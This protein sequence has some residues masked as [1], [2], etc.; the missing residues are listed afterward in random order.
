MSLLYNNFKIILLIQSCKSND[1]CK[2]TGL[3]S[4]EVYFNK[5]KTGYYTI[6]EL[7]RT[8]KIIQ[9]TEEGIKTGKIDEENSIDYILCNIL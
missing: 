8:L 3:K 7:V 4:N 6:G 1:I 5:D 2:T 9:K